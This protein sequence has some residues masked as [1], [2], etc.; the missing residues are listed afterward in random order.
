MDQFAADVGREAHH[1]DGCDLGGEAEPET[2]GEGEASDAGEGRG[3]DG[4]A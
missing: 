3:C 2:L 4:W 1:A